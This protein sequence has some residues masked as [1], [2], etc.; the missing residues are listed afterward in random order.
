MLCFLGLRSPWEVN[1]ALPREGLCCLCKGT[2]FLAED[3]GVTNCPSRYSPLLH[4]LMISRGYRKWNFAGS[5]PRKILYRRIPCNV[6]IQALPPDNAWD[7]LAW[8]FNSVGTPE[9]QKDVLQGHS[10]IVLQDLRFAIIL[11]GVAF[12]C[13]FR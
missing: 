6:L 7:S 9:F 13:Y 4:C 10:G 8:D 2:C 12:A 5:S 3:L 1:L 11:R